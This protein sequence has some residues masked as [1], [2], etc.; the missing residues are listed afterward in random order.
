MKSIFL[1][2]VLLITI[3]CS[4]ESDNNEGEIIQVQNTA[5]DDLEREIIVIPEITYEKT[6]IY[7]FI[8]SM[9]NANYFLD[10][11]RI[12][13][14][15]SWEMIAKSPKVSYESITYYQYPFPIEKFGNYFSEP[16]TYFFASWDS[17]NS[18]FKN[19]DDFVLMTWTISDDGIKIEKE[20]LL[21]L[22]NY[23]QNY[24]IC[25]FRNNEKVYLIMQR[26]SNQ[27][28]HTIMLSQNLR[29]FIN[30]DTEI[31]SWKNRNKLLKNNTSSP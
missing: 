17:I 15:P 13:Q 8:D 3:S 12:K 31:Y 22:V 28:E 27:I 19:G 26:S 4:V 1:F 20:I 10:T 6:D 18:T 30:K 24:P 5:K 16:K 21:Y 9:R 29:N 7:D 11:N 25:C 23:R 14:I 2:I